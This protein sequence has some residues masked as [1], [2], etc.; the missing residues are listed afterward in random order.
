MDGNIGEVCWSVSIMASGRYGRGSL[1]ALLSVATHFQ[2]HL[3]CY[4]KHV[5]SSISEAIIVI[6]LLA[7]HTFFITTFWLTGCGQV[8]YRDGAR[9][10]F[11]EMTGLWSGPFP[12]IAKVKILYSF[13]SS[14]PCILMVQCLSTHTSLPFTIGEVITVL[15][16][17]E[18]FVFL[19]MSPGYFLPLMLLVCMLHFLWKVT[20]L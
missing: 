4:I 7:L 9:S 10:S 15:V 5:D 11:P 20:I 16:L 2:F 3:Q 18:C 8:N 1:M 12:C 13:S 17:F 14:S 19:G 6:Q